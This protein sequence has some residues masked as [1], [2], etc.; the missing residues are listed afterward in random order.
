MVASSRPI[1][2]AIGKGSLHSTVTIAAFTGDGVCAG[3]VRAFIG[4]PR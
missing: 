1:G 2:I 3:T 4:S